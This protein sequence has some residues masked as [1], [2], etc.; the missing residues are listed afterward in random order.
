MSVTAADLALYLPSVLATSLSAPS[1]IGG[2]ASATK[3]T[4]STIGE[5]LFAMAANAASGGDKTQY[6]KLFQANDGDEDL[7]DAVMWLANGMDDSDGTGYTT[8]A[9][10]T[11]AAD[12]SNKTLR[13]IGNDSTGDAQ[14]EFA[15]AGTSVA[16][17]SIAFEERWAV[18]LRD[19]STGAL[20]PAAGTITIKENGVTIA[21]IPP[22][23]YSAT[24][25]IDFGLA[26]TLDDTA[27]TTNAATAPSGITFARP[28]TV[29]AGTA[30]ANS[31]T[32]TSGTMQGLWLRW[33]CAEA[34]RP[35][36]DIEI[37][38][39]CEGDTV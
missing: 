29:G 8:T 24:A 13:V 9:Q 14:D 27:T 15:L 31:G 32:L 16:T 26:A 25:E 39:L 38:P 6:G 21:V 4:G 37:Y 30:V 23:A 12:G 5:V 3:I 18:E 17:G 28:R 33:T 1:N 20:T 7:T 35:S 19:T 34:R 11:S 22:G 2:A 10:S 36:P